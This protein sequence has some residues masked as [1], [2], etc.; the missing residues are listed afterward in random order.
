MEQVLRSTWEQFVA[1]TWEELART[2]VY[3]L[4]ARHTPGFWPE[5]VGSWWDTAHRIDLVAVGYTERK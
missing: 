2:S 3:D 1:I 4:A 5:A